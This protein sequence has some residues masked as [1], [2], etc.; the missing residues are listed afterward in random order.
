VT[1][2]TT[3]GDSSTIRPPRRRKTHSFLS[4][5]ENKK[6]TP[7]YLGERREE[8]AST[9]DSGTRTPHREY[10]L[11]GLAVVAGVEHQQGEEET[12]RTYSATTPPPSPRRRR[13]E[14]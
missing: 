14:P 2:N 3:T 10:H 4:I 9:E 12:E 7:S 1:P 6:S 11:H 5:L 13:Q 8:W